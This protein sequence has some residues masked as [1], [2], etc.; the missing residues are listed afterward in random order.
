MLKNQY[1][2]DEE[3]LGFDE[4][5]EDFFEEPEE[6]S[7][8]IKTYLKKHKGKLRTLYVAS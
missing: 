3:L 8:E 2:E 5:A 6:D 1:V 7:E 4:T